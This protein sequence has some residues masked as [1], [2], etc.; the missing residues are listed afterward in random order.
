MERG[1]I[2]NNL[3]FDRK[4]I[5]GCDITDERTYATAKDLEY[6]LQCI[7]DYRITKN[8]LLY[9]EEIYNKDL[10]INVS[11]ETLN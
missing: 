9:F 2:T 7:G 1:K 4:D 6:D 8:I 5:F 10:K 3:S 11:C